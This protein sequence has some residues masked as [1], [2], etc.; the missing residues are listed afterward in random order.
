MDSFSLEKTEGLYPVDI[1]QEFYACNSIQSDLD[2]AYYREDNYSSEKE[3]IYFI[4][5]RR[6]RQKCD[7]LEMRTWKAKFD[8]DLRK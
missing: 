2:R 3:D 7:S 4:L 5:Q 6:G 8:L 1:I